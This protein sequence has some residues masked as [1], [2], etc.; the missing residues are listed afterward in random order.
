MNAVYV[1]V[2]LSV[3]SRDVIAS[4]HAMTEFDVPELKTCTLWLFEGEVREPWFDERNVVLRA[5]S[6]TLWGNESLGCH[7]IA[8]RAAKDAMHMKVYLRPPALKSS[9]GRTHTF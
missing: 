9:P 7:R 6:R 3:S 2:P 4:G 8:I 1:L 5:S